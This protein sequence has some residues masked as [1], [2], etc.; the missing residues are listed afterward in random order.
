[1]SELMADFTASTSTTTSTTTSS[2]STTASEPSIGHVSGQTGPAPIAEMSEP[3][4][5]GPW[6]TKEVLYSSNGN[7]IYA[8][9]SPNWVIKESTDKTVIELSTL[10]DFYTSGCRPR[11]SI[12]IPKLLYS[13]YGRTPT[14]GWYAMRRYTDCV[15]RNEYCVGIWKN[16]A[17]AG[18]N[19]M[20]DLHRKFHFIHMDMKISNILVEHTSGAIAFADYELV[21]KEPSTNELLADVSP[22]LKWYYLGFGCEQFQP[23]RAWRTDLTMFGY[24]LADLTWGLT[25]RGPWEF[26]PECWK[27]RKRERGLALT[28]HQLLELRDSELLNSHPSVVAYLQKV[29]DILWTAEQPP[30]DAFYDELVALFH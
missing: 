22:D 6:T 17:V 20:R 28:D 5:F 19:F 25:G 26:Q 16:I 30:S 29:K 9:T 1:M 8:T 7:T 10:L 15:K 27:R 13:L 14:S 4:Q 11:Y 18:V 3:K 23:F 21:E 12:E 2:D 24:I